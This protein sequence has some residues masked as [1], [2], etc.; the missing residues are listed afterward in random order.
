MSHSD[1][2]SHG[3]E[4]VGHIVPEKTFKKILVC[5]LLLTIITVAAAQ[6]DLGKWNIVGALVIAS[7]KATLVI[8]VFMHGMYENR[9]LWIYILIPFVLVAIMIGGIFTDDPFRDRPQPFGADQAK[10]AAPQAPKSAHH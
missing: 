1:S 2:H 6:V 7:V 9:V 10:V 8:L 5:L 3:H 4:E